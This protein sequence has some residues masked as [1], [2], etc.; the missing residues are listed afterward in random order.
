M[1]LWACQNCHQALMFE[2]TVCERC[3]HQLGYLPDEHILSAV[4]PDGPDWVALAVADRRYRF[5][6]NWE[7]RGC[8]WMVPAGAGPYCAAC[9]HN[10]TIPDISYPA[11]HLRWQKLEAA[12]R[13]LI[14]S[15][16]SLSLPHPSASSGDKEPLIFDFL[17]D[18]SGRPPGRVMTGHDHGVITISAAEADDAAREHRRASMGEPYRTLLGH[19]RHE[20]G[21]Y[22]WDRLVRD[23]GGQESC[24]RL[25]GDERQDYGAALEQHYANG[26]H[27]HWQDGFVSPYASAHPWEDFAETFA[28]Y[29]HIADTLEMAKAFGVRV[30]PGAAGAESL[31]ADVA[32]DPYHA[33]SIDDLTGAWLPLTFAVNSI[34]RSMGQPDLYPFVL[35]PAVIGKL[36]YIHDLVHR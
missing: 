1:R 9:I 3:G 12:K 8:N 27:L 6:A 11:N 19:F 16:D 32:F 23:T 28:H 13:R 29:L 15:L 24:R 33:D 22:Y 30:E 7:Q 35:S 14:Y 4:E 21:H 18:V 20:V 17:A 5:C 36:G 10:R 25:F 26:A 31:S 2:N 34:N